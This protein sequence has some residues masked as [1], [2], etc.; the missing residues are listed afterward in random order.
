VDFNNEESFLQFIKTAIEK[1][2]L[3]LPTLPE[4][5]L[6]VRAAVNSGKASDTELAKII[7]GDPA[8]SA[9]LLQVANSPI[10]RARQKI[11]NIQTA[12]IRMGHNAI[13]T[14]IT[15]LAMQ[16]VFKPRLP[17]LDE[18]FHTIWKHSVNVSAVSRALAMHCGH[19][20]KEQAMLA[21]LIHQIG[22]LPILAVAEKNPAL[23]RDTEL[24]DR[25]LEN[26]HPAIGK[27]IMETWDMPESL[28]RVAWEY[29]DFQRDS[30][31]TAD[32]VDVV[33]VA[34]VESQMAKNPA[35]ALQTAEIKAFKKLGLDP[36]I[37]VLE[38]EGVSEEVR[39]T[40]LVFL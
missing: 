15:S 28:S 24:L 17:L 5:A 25:L 7:S 30:G 36:E 34:F 14:L 38:I 1:N 3:V 29:L 22:K 33:Q 31:P 6:K 40:E 21:G 9:R 11:E 20:D 23:G 26:L 39:E 32:Y 37:E 12:I 27:L 10:Y 16:Q 18:Y 19:L 35:L 13:R 8:L 4:V 2:E